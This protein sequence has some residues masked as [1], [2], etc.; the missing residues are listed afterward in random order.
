MEAN[1][2]ITH[3]SAQRAVF[4]ATARPLTEAERNWRIGGLALLATRVIQGFIYWGGGSRRF[5]YAPSKLDAW[6]GHNWMANK[7]QTAMPGAL[8]GFEH[9]I[10]FLLQHFWL[11]YTGVI[12]FSAAEL[13]AGA[14]LMAGFMTRASALVSMGFS[15]ILMAMF[16]WQGATCI[17]EWTMAA[18]NLAMGTTLLLG[19]SSA[20][21]LDNV[22]LARRPRLADSAWFRWASGA[23]PLPLADIPFRNLTLALFGFVLIYNV[24]TYSYFRGSVVTPFHSGPV[25]PTK[26]HVTL[27]N[28]VVLADGGIRVHAYLDAGTPEAPV[29]IVDAAVIGPDKVI[30]EHWDAKVLSALTKQ[31]FDNDYAYNKFGPG[32]YGIRAPMGA[33]AT[34]TLPWL[35]QAHTPANGSVIRFTDVDGRIFTAP[36]GV[37][38]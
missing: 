25:S 33:K 30:A 18:C 15:V 13:I 34:I 20:F 37:S 31:N 14:A 9:V 4:G 38:K 35:T 36:L 29:H 8:F 19:G 24:S 22:L 2:S 10:S 27:S 6:G 1:M 3:A 16:G 5:I 23:L 26:H 7:F 11:L 32:P 28:A 17:D 12:V 21:S